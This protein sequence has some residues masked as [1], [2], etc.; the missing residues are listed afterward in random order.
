MRRMIVD[1]PRPGLPSTNTDGL[2]MS[3]ARW[4]QL[5]GSQHTVAPV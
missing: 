3:F 4:N 1:L 5:I 2:L